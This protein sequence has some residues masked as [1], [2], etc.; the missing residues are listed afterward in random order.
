VA[1]FPGHTLIAKKFLLCLV[2]IHDIGKEK[3]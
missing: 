1:N 3:Q 2:L